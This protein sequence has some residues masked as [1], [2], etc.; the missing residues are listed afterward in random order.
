MDGQ[1]SA[2]A[3]GVL[4]VD[5]DSKRG[6]GEYFGAVD[7]RLDA[8]AEGVPTVSWDSERE[9]GEYFGAVGE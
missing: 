7:C 5:W 3:E 6:I 2:E 9:S 1:R 4:A 8:D